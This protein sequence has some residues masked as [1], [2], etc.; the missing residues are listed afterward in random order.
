MGSD[1]DMEDYGF[2]YSDEEQEE[3]D[4]DIENQYYNSKGLVETDPKGA[5]EGFAE[6]VHM[7]PEKAEW[8]FKA[9]KQTV[10]LYYK[11]GKFKEMMDSY[12]EMLTYI[13]SAVTRNYSEKCING[14]MD[15]VAGSASQNFSLLQEFYQTTLKA[16]EEAKNERLWFKTNLKLCKIWFDMGEYG[17]MSKILKELHKSCKKEDGTDDEKKG[18]QL[19]E[20]YAIEIQMYTETKNNKKLKELYNKALSVKSAI[21]HPRIMGIIRECGGKMHMAERKWAEAA[22]DF[23]EAFKNYDEAGNHRRI[24]C[25]KY[26][27]LANMLMESEVNPFDG[28]EAKPYKNDPEILAMTNLIA[29]YQRNEILEFEKIIKSNRRTIMD[30]PF[31]RNYIEDL[32][33]KVRT[34]VLLKLI[35][36]YTRIRI[37]FISKELNVPEKD[38]EDLLVSLILDSRI[39]GYIDQVNGLLECRDRSKGMK[40]YTAIDKWNT[41]LRSLYQTVGNKVC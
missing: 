17:R 39:D 21:P 40:K 1:A 27:V 29:A 38:V 12:R 19:L 24:Q 41:Q 8:G 9:L 31:I 33:R 22:T 32:L 4:V 11:L 15:F 23:F 13:K 2:E 7:E 36:P 18:T 25:L 37:P 34:Q 5:L 35:K 16:L 3:Q 14:I 28:Q 26:L 6:V 10:K 20:V 30:D